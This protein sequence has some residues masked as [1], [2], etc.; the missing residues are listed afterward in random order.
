MEIEGISHST[1][2][3]YFETLNAGEFEAT[4]EL[5]A[6]E[7]AM[8]PPFESAMVGRDA[9]VQYLRKEAS[10][11]TALPQAGSA[12]TETD[13]Q[14][15][16]KVQMPMFGVNVTWYFTIDADDKIAFTRIKLN[17]S[18]QELVNLKQ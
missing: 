13:Y 12:V 9:I 6:P 17:A 3:K 11:L 18:P 15:A 8:Q 10:G 16:G 7:G 1:I 4:S 5:F 2:L 14:I